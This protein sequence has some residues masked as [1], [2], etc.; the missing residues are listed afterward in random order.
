MMAIARE[1]G[2][3]RRTIARHIRQTIEL[4]PELQ[5]KVD[6]IPWYADPYRP[7][8]DS[9]PE[10][11]IA[12][13]EARRMLPTRPSDH[14]VRLWTRPGTSPRLATRRINGMLVTTPASVARFVDAKYGPLP[15]GPA[16]TIRL[17]PAL[18]YPSPAPFEV[19]DAIRAGAIAP[20]RLGLLTCIDLP[21]VHRLA[22]FYLCRPLV[23]VAAN[24][25]PCHLLTRHEVAAI[26]S[27]GITRKN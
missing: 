10:G 2:C 3:E 21:N 6:A 9:A 26:R 27:R 8:R 25:T 19:A 20:F 13:H 11:Y 23:D 4:P 7:T 15:T 1:I 14:T 22:E 5:A 12:I 16:V 18:I 24:A 17:A